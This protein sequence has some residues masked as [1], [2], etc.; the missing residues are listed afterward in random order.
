MGSFH[1]KRNWLLLCSPYPFVMNTRDMFI[2]LQSCNKFLHHAYLESTSFIKSI[3]YHNDDPHAGQD[4]DTKCLPVSL[5]NNSSENYFNWRQLRIE[6]AYPLENMSKN[7]WNW[8][9]NMKVDLPTVY[10]N[11]CYNNKNQRNRRIHT[12]WNGGISVSG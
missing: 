9:A 5:A 8:I 1:Y 11:K 3:N 6:E 12:R 7:L 10:M 2:P 4:F